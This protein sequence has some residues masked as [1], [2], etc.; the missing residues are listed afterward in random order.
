MSEI[1]AISNASVY[2]KWLSHYCGFKANVSP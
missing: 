1:D 2:T